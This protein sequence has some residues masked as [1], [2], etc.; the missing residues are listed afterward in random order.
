MPALLLGKKDAKRLR[1]VLNLIGKQ[2][3]IHREN[4]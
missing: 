4:L 2:T 3:Y 1:E